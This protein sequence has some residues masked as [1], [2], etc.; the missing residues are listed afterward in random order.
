MGI[1]EL[2]AA[3]EE[4]NAM[5]MKLTEDIATLTK[6][7]QELDSAVAEATK[8]RTAEKEKNTQTIKEAKEAQDA[9]NSAMSV[10]K[11]FYAKAAQATALLQ[12]K[13]SHLPELLT[14]G[15]KMGSEEWDAL[16]NPNFKG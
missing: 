4:G 6:E 11:D 10:L 2:D 15:V 13:S 12:K 7:V 9:V 8:L 16:A 3:I 14:R 5:I 1:D